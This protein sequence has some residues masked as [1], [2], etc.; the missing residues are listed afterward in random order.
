MGGVW[1][2]QIRTARN[3]ISALLHDFGSQL[4]DESLRT[5]MCET[6]A[7]VNSRPLTADTLCDPSS[8]EPLT[9]NNLLT[10]KSKVIL[11]PPGTFIK[12]D[13]Y[14][15][16]RWRRVQYIAN[17]FWSRWRKEYL[18]SLQL[19]QKWTA[20]CRNLSVNDIVIIKDDN[21][22]RNHW[23]LGRISEVYLSEDGLVRTVKVDCGE[24]NF[25]RPV[26]KLVLLLEKEN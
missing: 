6:A 12:E 24:S 10:M 2:R 16:K 20:P 18:Q 7:I 25:V 5:V 1:E 26:H 11:S 22:P 9:P 17:E 14:S 3:A 4:D 15:R 8:P 23:K 21:I 19:R 13:M